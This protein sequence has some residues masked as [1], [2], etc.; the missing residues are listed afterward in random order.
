MMRLWRTKRFRDWLVSF[1]N[2][3]NA[4]VLVQPYHYFKPIRD[5]SF[6]KRCKHELVHECVMIDEVLSKNGVM[7]R[8]TD[9]RSA[10]ITE[11]HCE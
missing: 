11:E 6:L 7:I 4:L 10:H 8:L 1:D 3:V 9:E 2:S 5:R